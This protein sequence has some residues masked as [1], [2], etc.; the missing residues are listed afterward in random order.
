MMSHVNFRDD[1]AIIHPKANKNHKKTRAELTMLTCSAIDSSS[2]A[3]LM[4]EPRQE[5]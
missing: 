5:S 1:F 3:S 4:L 2:L